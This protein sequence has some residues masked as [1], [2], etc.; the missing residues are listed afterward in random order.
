[1]G[2]GGRLSLSPAAAARPTAAPARAVRR[3]CRPASGGLA[4]CGDLP[5]GDAGLPGLRRSSRHE[6]TGLGG[7]P[8]GRQPSRRGRRCGRRAGAAPASARRSARP[9][10]PPRAARRHEVGDQARAGSSRAAGAAGAQA[11]ERSPPR[12]SAAPRRVLGHPRH[13]ELPVGVAGVV[14]PD[15]D[16]PARPRHADHLA[17]RRRTASGSA[18]WCITATRDRRGRSCRRRTAARSRRRAPALTAGA[19]SRH[20][21]E[22]PLRGVDARSPRSPRRR[23]AAARTPVPQPTSRTAPAR[24]VLA[25]EVGALAAGS[26]RRRG[27][28][29]TRRTRAAISVEVGLAHRP[30]RRRALVET[31]GTRHRARR[32][33]AEAQD[34]HDHPQADRDRRHGLPVTDEVPTRG[35]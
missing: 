23:A 4:V 14:V 33:G 35:R 11:V 20:H 1:M 29:A 30:S 2:P 3:P 19:R 16:P 17:E 34:Q 10:A 21:V 18:M 5:G 32:R 22:H 25:D 6:R 24:A 7:C 15:H 9:A 12:G 13:Q 26:A 8:A 27:P 28:A 31:S